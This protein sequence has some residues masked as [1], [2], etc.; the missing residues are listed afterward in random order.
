MTSW[1]VLMDN[2]LGKFSAGDMFSREICF[3]DHDNKTIN[4]A[5]KLWEPYFWGM[6]NHLEPR[7]L[8]L[9]KNMFHWKFFRSG[10][11]IL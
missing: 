4:D 10:I 9:S 7:D 2:I 3:Y 1:Q 6:L 8:A 11:R 5:E